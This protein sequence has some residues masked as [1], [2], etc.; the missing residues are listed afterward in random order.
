MLQFLALPLRVLAAGRRQ[1]VHPR[2]IKKFFLDTELAFALGKL[3]VNYFSVERNDV[4]RELLQLLR[5]HDAAFGEISAGELFHAL[6]GPLDQVGKPDAKFNHALV[7]V[8][9]ERFRNHA[10]F[11]Q[12]GP[13]LI[14]APGVVVTHAHGGF[15]RIAADDDQLHAFSQMVGESSH[16]TSVAYFLFLGPEIRLR[17]SQWS[18]SL[19]GI[20][21]VF[22]AGSNGRFPLKPIVPHNAMKQE[23][24]EDFL[25]A[26]EL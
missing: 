11:V 2:A 10:A 18:R 15:A 25:A 9:V 6:G 23:K 22:C 19:A 16:L 24:I 14:G 17:R 3:F 20:G 26:G 5:K 21:F 13:E 8:I 12:D 7:V 1:D 4:R